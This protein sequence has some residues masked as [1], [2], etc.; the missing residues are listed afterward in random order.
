MG[1]TARSPNE[2]AAHPTD[3]VAETKV[4]KPALN[5]R[6]GFTLV[7]LMIAILFLAVG[8]IAVTFAFGRGMFA[9]TDAETLEQAV[10]LTQERLENLKGTAFASIANE[11]RA[12]VSGWTGFDRQVTV[13]QPAGT[14]ANFKQVVVTVYWSTGGAELSTI[15]TTYWVNN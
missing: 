8:V 9:T 10:A 12:P 11:A 14:N 13:T 7:E 3:F 2:V 5:L 1:D 4:L 6:R 15:T